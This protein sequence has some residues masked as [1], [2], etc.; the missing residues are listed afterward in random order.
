MKPRPPTMREKR[1]YILVRMDPPTLSVDGRDFYYAIAE[2]VTSIYG[3]TGMARIQPAVISC[4]EGYA[5]IRCTRSSEKELLA[6]LAAVSHVHE[7]K[8]VIRSIL[9]SGTMCSLHQ[10]LAE[11]K[12]KTPNMEQDVTFQGRSFIAIR[13]QGTKVDLFEKGFK[14]QELLFLTE[15]DLEE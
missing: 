8:M 9:T 1:R 4:G 2:S 12:E 7:K 14:N 3:D 6:G 5:I 13:F 11:V 10:Y 15:E